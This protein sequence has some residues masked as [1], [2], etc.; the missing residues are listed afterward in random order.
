MA[1]QMA[2]ITPVVLA[3]GAG[4]R[5]WPI[6]REQLPKQFQPLVG[7]YSTYQQTLMRVSDYALYNPPIVITNSDFRF[8]AQRQAED[9]G[10]GGTVILEP[11]RRDSAAAMAVAAVFAERQTP[12]G[13]VVALAADHVVLDGALFS[14]AIELGCKAATQGHIVV[15]GLTPT[16]P[17]TSYGYIDPGEQFENEPDLR[18][19]T[20]F[21][22]K[23]D[24][25]TALRYVSNGYLWNSGNFLFRSDVM[26]TEFEKYAPDVLLA[27]THAVNEGEIDLGFFRLQKERFE[28]SPQTSIDYA[29]IEKTKKISVVRGRF[30]WSDIG[31]W[32]AIWEIA[33][34]DAAQNVVEGDGVAV[35]AEGCLIHSAGP[36]TAVLGA[37]DLVVVATK[38]A[39]LVAPKSRVQEVKGLVEVLREGAN[40]EVTERHTRV[41]SPWGFADDMLT[42]DRFGVRRITID[43]GARTSLQ[44][45]MNRAEHWVVVRGTATVSI[46]DITKVLTENESMYVPPGGTH[47]ISNEGRVPLE[48][49]EIRTGDYIGDDDVL[50]VDD[51][52]GKI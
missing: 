41:H 11:A 46:D 20:A 13:L 6:S 16:G 28:A 51:D 22:E 25:E 43:P 1:D 5:L 32:D 4:S 17:R 7:R 34:K 12:G 49:I 39:V 19:V 14:E 44:R 38:D 23:P 40:Q 42:G 27:A 15:F 35:G 47:R 18:L 9:V 8:F 33:P 50:R 21:V 36:M 45:H 37:K 2:K 31:S 3:G 24:S 10:V 26:I 52:Y 29:V 30:G 48:L